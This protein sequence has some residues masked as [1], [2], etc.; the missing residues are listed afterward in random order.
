MRWYP[1]MLM[2]APLRV[3][4]GSTTRLLGLLLI[5]ALLAAACSTE[6]EDAADSQADTGD[7]IELDDTGEAESA[8]P[9]NPVQGQALSQFTDADSDSAIGQPAPDLDGVSL[10]GDIMTIDQVDGRGKIYGFFAHWCPHCQAEVPVLVDYLETNRL[11]ENVDFHAV[12]TAVDDSRENYPPID[13][14]DTENWPY[15]VLDDSQMSAIAAGFGLPAFPYFVVVGGDGTVVQ[16][17]AGGL[18]DEEAIANLI[19]IAEGSAS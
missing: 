11:P 18:P 8:I 13:W 14:F 2:N 9:D 3:L 4:F 16:R 1:V 15:P 17:I 6:T 12:S 19:A 10:K 7:G 5:A